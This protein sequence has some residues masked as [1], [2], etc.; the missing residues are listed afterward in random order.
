MLSSVRRFLI[1][2]LLTGAFAAS[3][4]E[5]DVNSVEKSDSAHPPVVHPEIGNVWNG[6]GIQVKFLTRKQQ[7]SYSEVETLDRDIHTIQI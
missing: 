6:S 4:Q 5:A 1:P 2:L 3:A 7:Y